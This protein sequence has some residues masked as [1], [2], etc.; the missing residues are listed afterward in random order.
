MNMA[1]YSIIEFE[2]FFQMLSLNHNFPI[3]DYHV[4]IATYNLS[5]FK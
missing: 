1:Y 5:S 3:L 4:K 2:I